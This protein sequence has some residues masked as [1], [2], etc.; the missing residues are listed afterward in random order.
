MTSPRSLFSPGT[1]LVWKNRG[2][3]TEAHLTWFRKCSKVAC[4]SFKIRSVTGM[5][6]AEGKNY[7]RR[8]LILWCLSGVL[9]ALQKVK[10]KSKEVSRCRQML[11]EGKRTDWTLT[12]PSPPGSVASSQWQLLWCSSLC[13][14]GDR[15]PSFGGRRWVTH[16]KQNTLSEGMNKGPSFWGPKTLVMGPV[17]Q[18]CSS[19][20]RQ[21]THRG[22][23][24]SMTTNRY[25]EYRKRIDKLGFTTHAKHCWE[26]IHL[27]ASMVI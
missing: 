23:P 9:Y 2:T 8:S 7:W 16:T 18:G 21:T 4:Y 15:A 13:R 5:Y 20:E 3:L 27:T 26:N 14:G 11:W 10:D 19:T 24:F 6:L 25:K 1:C 12:P 17:D 22:K